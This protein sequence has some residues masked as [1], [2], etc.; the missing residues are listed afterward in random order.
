LVLLISGESFKALGVKP[1]VEAFF[2][3]EFFLEEIFELQQV[4][5][6]GTETD[7]PFDLEVI[8]DVLNDAVIFIFVITKIAASGNVVQVELVFGKENSFIS[9]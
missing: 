4:F 2:E 7:D 6:L 3:C 5:E 9:V 1:V 8:G